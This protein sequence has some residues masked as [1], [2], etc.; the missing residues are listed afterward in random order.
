MRFVFEKQVHLLVLLSLLLEA[1]VEL[2]HLSGPLAWS[3]VNFFFFAL[4]ASGLG[5]VCH[6][7]VEWAI[8]YIFESLL[9][10]RTQGLCNCLKL[11][12]L[13]C[14]SHRLTLRFVLVF[15]FYILSSLEQKI[16]C[17]I[18]NYGRF[19]FW[20]RGFLWRFFNLFLRFF[21]TFKG[22]IL[23]HYLCWLMRVYKCVF[24]D[25]S[26]AFFF[27]FFLETL[28]FDLS[29]NPFIL[30]SDPIGVFLA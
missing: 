7:R 12:L 29:I 26:Q 8:S 3:L 4:F 27:R 6:Q 15:H 25:I 21:C 20:N 10:N 14:Y 24:V 9:Q 18:I 19:L 28:F 23:Y 11:L 17:L 13:L 22:L 2:L 16:Y 5:L 1:F 30:G